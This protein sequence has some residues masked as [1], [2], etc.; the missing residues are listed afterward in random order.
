MKKGRPN[1][2]PLYLPLENVANLYPKVRFFS[3]TSKHWMENLMSFTGY[4]ANVLWM[5]SNNLVCDFILPEYLE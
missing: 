1:G 2:L 3:I 4:L 5:H